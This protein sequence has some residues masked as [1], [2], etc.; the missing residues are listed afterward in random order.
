MTKVDLWLIGVVLGVSFF[1]T[2]V[3]AWGAMRFGIKRATGQWPYIKPVWD[4]RFMPRGGELRIGYVEAF[5]DGEWKFD[6]GQGLKTVYWNNGIMGWFGGK[7]DDI[8]ADDFFEIGGVIFRGK[9]AFEIMFGKKITVMESD[10][11][12]YRIEAEKWKDIAQ[13]QLHDPQKAIAQG[14]ENLGAIAKAAAPM[15]MAGANK[16]QQQRG[17]K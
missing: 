15:L 17:K 16:N 2:I 13:Q 5:N 8:D 1:A 11:E 14:T 6:K 7:P 12:H 3:A 4:I 10:L 9:A